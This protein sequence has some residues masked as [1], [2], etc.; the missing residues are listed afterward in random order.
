MANQ[1]MVITLL[2]DDKPGIV[3]QV[4]DIIAHEQGNWL[5][6]KMSQLAGKFAGIL[7]VSI[8]D[9]N[10][11]SLSQAL[12]SLSTKGIQ[13]LIEKEHTS[14]LSNGK[15]LSFELIGADRVGIVSEIALAFSEK[16]INIDELETRCSSMPWSGE[17]LFEATGILIAPESINKDELLDKLDSIEDKLGIDIS[18]TEQLQ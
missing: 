17:P 8:D 12:K 6:S 16:S 15:L 1:H 2:S 13:V 9:N 3:Q 14:E 18:I 5:E 11:D 7:K 4:A 10:I